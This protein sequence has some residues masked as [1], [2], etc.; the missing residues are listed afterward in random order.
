MKQAVTPYEWDCAMYRHAIEIR[1]IVA[2]KTS[3]ENKRA[4]PKNDICNLEQGVC[5]QTTIKNEDTDYS[6]LRKIPRATTAPSLST[7][8]IP[9]LRLENSQHAPGPNRHKAAIADLD[10]N[11]ISQSTHQALSRL[12]EQTICPHQLAETGKN[13]RK[14]SF[15]VGCV[16]CEPT[17]KHKLY[18]STSSQQLSWTFRK[19]S[20][21]NRR[22]RLTAHSPDE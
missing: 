13:W 7:S 17:T 9:K 2:A 8:N 18:C 14:P 20:G 1:Q 4:I 16:W 12:I 11:K 19:T 21:C 10:K 15:V 5:P 22:I 6:T 3:I